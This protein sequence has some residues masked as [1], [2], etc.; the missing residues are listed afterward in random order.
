MKERK[1]KY[2]KKKKKKKIL[3]KTENKTI[4]KKR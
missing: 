2:S 1:A 4:Q 3:T